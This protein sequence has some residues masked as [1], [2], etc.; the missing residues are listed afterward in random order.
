MLAK[1]ERML[2]RA[3]DEFHSVCKRRKLKVNVGKSKVMVYERPKDEM[4]SF[5]KPYRVR[6]ECMKECRVWL[7][8]ERMEEVIKFK[9]L[10]SLM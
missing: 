5:A 3:V 1:S 9:Y 4:S 7:G 8:E 2:Q 10:G 6:T